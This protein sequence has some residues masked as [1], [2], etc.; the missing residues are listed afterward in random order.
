VTIEDGQSEVFV[1]RRGR[2]AIAIVVIVAMLAAV[3]SVPR[4][5]EA[6]LSDGEIVA[7][8][9]GSL[10]GYLLLVVIATAAVYG[11]KKKKPVRRVPVEEFAEPRAQASDGLRFASDCQPRE[12]Q[13]PMLCW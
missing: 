1:P 6:G 13:L 3:L 4:R 2:R 10:A 12:G 5:A 7:V 8:V 11:H 9:F